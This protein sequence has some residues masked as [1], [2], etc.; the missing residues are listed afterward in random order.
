M[1]RTYTGKDELQREFIQIINSMTG[2]Y[3]IWEVWKDMIWC[4]A[5]TIS[6]RVDDRYRESREKTYMSIVEKYDEKDI[7]KFAQL[8]VLIHKN[9]VRRTD[10][11]TFGDFLGD[12]FMNLDLGNNLG[13]Q[14][15]TPYSICQMMARITIEDE[16]DKMLQSIDKQG[17]FSCSDCACGAGATLIAAA[18]ESLAKGVN[19][20]YQIMFAAQ[21]IDSTTALMCYIQLSLL[22]CAGYVVI[23]DSLRYPMTGHVLFGENSERCWYTPMF[24]EQTWHERREIEI[25]RQRFRAIMGVFDKP[26]PQDE[27]PEDEPDAAPVAVEPGIVE[28][29]E[30]PSLL[31]GMSLLGTIQEQPKDTNP[32]PKAARKPAKKRTESIEGQVTFQF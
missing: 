27:Q 25:A 24:F 12:M 8:F 21:E 5:I 29:E 20:P 11:G 14:F 3:N 31:S 26:K 23:G 4:I 15:F 19:Y 9:A 22:G 28:I 18:E 30:E 32:K 13:G 17:W 16:K 1:A 7:D 6:N 2:K 10:L